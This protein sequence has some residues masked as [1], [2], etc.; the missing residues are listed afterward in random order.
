LTSGNG[1]DSLQ[2]HSGSH[3]F[4]TTRTALSMRSP[5]SFASTLTVVSSSGESY[6]LTDLCMCTDYSSS[7]PAIPLLNDFRLVISGVSFLSDSGALKCCRCK[8]M[9]PYRFTSVSTV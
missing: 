2:S 7:P 6:T 5:K 8:R 1:M 4:P 3:G 9:R